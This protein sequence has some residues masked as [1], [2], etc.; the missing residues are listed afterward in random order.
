MSQER[1]QRFLLELPT[2]RHELPYS[3]ALLTALF[4]QT[5]PDSDAPLETIA[6]TLSR[7]QGLTAKVLA[8]ANSA[9][10]GLQQKVTT[11]PRA[12]AVLGLAEVRTL[13]LSVGV[14]ALAEGKG[15]PRDFDLTAYWEHQLGVA[16]I[17]RALAPTMGCPDADALF[18]AGVLH[19][20]GKLL[21]ALHSPD[22][23]RA[24][25]D[26][27]QVG[28]TPYATAEEDY[29]GIEHGVI[30]AMVLG[31]WNLPE[32]LTE[33]VNWHHAPM[34]APSDRRPA[35]ALCVADALAHV[36]ED[37][38]A[39]VACP[40]REVLIRFGL[41]DRAALS[42]AEEAL[43]RNNPALFASGLAA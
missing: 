21:T 17:A 36:L 6:D 18:T 4:A 24:I 3:P 39:F 41:D 12:L 19:D 16:V 40:W 27:T 9:F 34:H 23:W 26:L 25:R 37:R 42:L 8:L 11:V 30:G 15:F 2:L 29:W 20:L 31:S 5:G 13:V 10:Y 38:N 33:P 1:G 32:S 28:N 43:V 14:K 7:D 35:L 22:D